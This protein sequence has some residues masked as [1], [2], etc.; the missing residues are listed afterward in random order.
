MT[1]QKGFKA[2]KGDKANKKKFPF[3]FQQLWFEGKL[4]PPHQGQTGSLYN[5][6]AVD[7]REKPHLIQTFI[8]RWGFDGTVTSSA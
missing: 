2:N 1:K 7:V 8:P 6:L 5:R 3:Q 4:R